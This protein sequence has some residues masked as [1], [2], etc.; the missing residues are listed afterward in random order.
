LIIY[1]G[2][3]SGEFI[4]REWVKHQDPN[5][6]YGAKFTLG[7]RAVELPQ[8]AIISVTR[9]ENFNI[10]RIMIN[11]TINNFVKKQLQ[12]NENL[13]Y[14][15]L[16]GQL[17]GG[18]GQTITVWKKGSSMNNFRK[19]GAH[20]FAMRFFSWV[21]YGGKIQAYFLTWKIS[22]SIPEDN[23][24][25]EIVKKYGKHYDGGKLLKSA[26]QPPLK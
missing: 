7:D 1:I 17:Q 10:F 9:G 18:V 23:E 13:L 14:A 11:G 6:K 25:K 5:N 8:T 3:G 12:K 15:E 16:S 20:K 2:K 19:K 26:Q 24:I 4:L 22:N 21:F